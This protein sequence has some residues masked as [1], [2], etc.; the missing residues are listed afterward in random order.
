[1]A[2]LWFYVDTKKTHAKMRQYY[3]LKYLS[4]LYSILNMCGRV[5]VIIQREENEIH[6]RLL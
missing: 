1:M 3:M 2:R 6:S 4:I 5:Y